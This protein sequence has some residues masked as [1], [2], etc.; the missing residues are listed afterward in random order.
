MNKTEKKLRETIASMQ[1]EGEK[2]SVLAVAK[3]AGVSNATIHNRY[4]EVR[5]EINAIK[6][7]REDHKRQQAEG[8]VHQLRKQK[9]DKHAEL[10]ASKRREGAALA[11]LMET[12]RLCDELQKEND[13]LHHR[14]GDKA[15]VLAINPD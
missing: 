12:Y 6:S 15:E 2:I 11:H 14:L 1:S 13:A 3:R 4:P 5:D 7:K 9:K 8:Q 10:K